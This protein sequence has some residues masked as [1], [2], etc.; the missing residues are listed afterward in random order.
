MSYDIIYTGI[1]LDSKSQKDLSNWYKAQKKSDLLQKKCADV[2][3]LKVVKSS[4]KDSYLTGLDIGDEARID[5]V[6]YLDK[7]DIQIAIGIAT[8]S[9]KRIGKGFVKIV[10]STNLDSVKL[11]QYKDSSFRQCHGPT[12]YGKIGFLNSDRKVITS[13]SDVDI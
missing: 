6:G 5:I 2:C 7:E 3:V 8:N 1:F 13:L 9:G 11:S 10:I 4:V 12:L